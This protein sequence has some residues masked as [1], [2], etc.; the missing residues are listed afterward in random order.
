M[1]SRD[2]GF[3]TSNYP[4]RIGKNLN[5]TLVPCTP[6]TFARLFGAPNEGLIK[7]IHGL[8]DLMAPGPG[9]L[10]GNPQVVLELAS[11]TASGSSRHQKDSRKP[12]P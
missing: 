11:G 9:S 3:D 5:G 2:A 12:V 4:V 7:L 8:S 1:S 10:I 6:A